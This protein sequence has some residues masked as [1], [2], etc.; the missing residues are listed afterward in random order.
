MTNYRE[1]QE[2]ICQSLNYGSCRTAREIFIQIWTSG[3]F[4]S[5]LRAIVLKS[6]TLPPE[7]LATKQA[8]ARR[9]AC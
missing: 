2:K 7:V 9:S 3:I 6:T 4:Y 1:I 5:W 8:I